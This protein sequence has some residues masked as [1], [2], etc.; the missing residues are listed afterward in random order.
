MAIH[1]D[2]RAL[3]GF[4]PLSW[5]TR[6]Y[7]EHF[8]NGKIPLA[9]DVPT[10]LGKTS[11]IAL[12][13]IARAK[14][15]RLPRRLVY[16]VDRRAVVDQ[17]TDEAEKLRRRLEDEARHLKERLG[18]RDRKLPISTL[19]GAHVDNREWLDDPAAPAIVVG[20]VDMIG[21]RLLFQGYGVS[22]K[23][24]PYQAGLLGVDALIVLDEAHLVPPFAHL[25]RSI[26]QDQS[27]W[28]QSEVDRERLPRFAVLP[29][30]ATL[31]ASNEDLEGRRPFRLDESDAGDKTVA[32]RLGAR[33]RLRLV[34]LAEKDQDKQVA[35][36]AWELATRPSKPARVV[37]FCDR[38][39]KKDDGGGPSAQGVRDAIEELAKGDR[40]ANRLKTDIHAPE[41]L[42]GARRVHERE[43]V[44][45]RLRDLG[46]IGGDAPPDKPAFLVATAAGEVGIDI[47]ADHMVSDLVAWERMVQRLG[48]A[49][50][51]GKGA[52]EIAVFWCVPSLKN[53][54]APTEA[55]KRAFAAFA[56][57]DAIESLPSVDG[58]FDASPGALR[59]F[60]EGARKDED[61]GKRI[62]KATTPEPLRPALN[63]ALV[64][65]WSMTSLKEHTGRPE[66]A[67]WLRGWV[68][69][70]AQT[71]LVWR[72]YLPVRLDGQGRPIAPRKGEKEVEDYFEAAPLHES[73]K[74]ETETHRV[75]SWLQQRAAELLARKPLAPKAVNENEDNATDVANIDA[76]ASET[77]PSTPETEG[78]QRR[79]IAVLI[80]S[81]G[82]T[83]ERHCTLGEFARERKGKTKEE[84]H[85]GLAGKVVVVDTRL[86]GL[87][88]GLLSPGSCDHVATADAF[89]DWS[90]RAGFRVRRVKSLSDDEGAGWRFEHG[91]ALRH[92]DEGAVQ[93]WLIVEHFEG[94]AQ[95]ED[96]RSISKPQELA[97][98]QD[99]VGR[100]MVRIARSV[101][102]PDAAV[103]ALTVGASL[104]DEGKKAARW[105]RAFK[106]ERDAKKFNLSLPLAKTRGPIDQ[107]VLAG[108]RHEL[109]S[110]IELE[111][112]PKFLK[113]QEDW[114]DLVLHLVAAH[115][116]QARPVIETRGCEA[117]T[118]SQLEER[119]HVA[120]LRFARL[121][122]R[123]GPWGMAWWE[124]L[125]RAADQQ[126]SRENAAAED[127]GAP[128]R[129]TGAPATVEG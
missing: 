105:Q 127:G 98:H 50:R 74:L 27:L 129:E 1:T 45:K 32:Q 128:R 26:E 46:F 97:Q 63:R 76:G 14:G 41:L 37:V 85:E 54:D 7:R 118:P 119:A 115:H 111:K 90:E 102:L 10:G 88:D 93:E 49:N 33:K 19:R 55:E 34:P 60:A 126:A 30:S 8:G 113:L 36:A 125:L 17:A 44:A 122:G 24:R 61:L 65:A 12:W 64:D 72:R 77:K 80:L 31:R 9:V 52:A 82:G 73:E 56:S 23:M 103:E 120:A 112:H 38:R 108:Y 15:A 4:A 43:E 66:V 124:A 13:L 87:K 25:L 62:D 11:V 99:W 83:L 57:K 96:A 81:P 101:G 47:D 6:L 109:G 3:T 2:F 78:L 5:Q 29:L 58:A 121:Q 116:G 70:V 104:H 28:A 53:G 100:E 117:A 75:V 106:A 84:F 94:A 68:K 123:W 40:R 21:S 48:R 110:L 69:E 39:D 89:S 22:A 20:T 95:K 71:T 35:Q 79:D 59:R 18:L 51:R 16:I 114:R 91:F 67:P 86:A 107:A 42:V 92:D